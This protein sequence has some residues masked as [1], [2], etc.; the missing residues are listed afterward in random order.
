MTPIRVL[1]VDDHTIVREGLA[2]IIGSAHGMR[3]AGEASDGREALHLAGL[4]R[5]DVAVMDIA[6]PALNGI[7]AA[8]LIRENFPEV[9]ILML[10]M[11]HTSEHIYRSIQAGAH[12]YILKE[13]AG[14]EIVSA[15]RE[16]MA[17]KHY[18][19]K[20]VEAPFITGEDSFLNIA[21]GPLDSLSRREKEVLQLVVEGKTSAEI[22]A[23]L[24]LSR[25]SV[26]TYRSRL[27]QK[28]GISDIAS[29]VKFAIQHGITSSL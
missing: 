25:K 5:P 10:T 15:I 4:L 22:A 28:L 24:G 27:M 14:A 17:G 11:Y 3:V 6:L 21:K 23:V 12:G 7:E 8:R 9:K 20:G 1:I 18:F 26:E 16:I 29:L 2:V 19:G 13:S